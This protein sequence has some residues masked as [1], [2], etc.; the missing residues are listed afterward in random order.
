MADG[1]YKSEY[2]SC[3]FKTSETGNFRVQADSVIFK[4]V[5]LIQDD[6]NGKFTDILLEN[7][8][9]RATHV[10]WLA[11]WSDRIYLIANS[12][13]LSFVNAVNLGIEP[14]AGLH[15]DSY[16]GVFEVRDKLNTKLDF[17]SSLSP[18]VGF[19]QLPENW[20]SYLLERPFATQILSVQFE[21]EKFFG[22]IDKGK[23]D[24]VRVG[25]NLVSAKSDPR[26]EA[27]AEVVQ[28]NYRT[29]K[30][31]LFELASVGDRLSSRF[32]NK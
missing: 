19:P 12:Q 6:G 26:F 32:E 3:T 23:A 17:G 20:A 10:S 8:K 5:T 14:R 11:T 29:A 22:T 24:G 4:P 21:G 31:Q 2:S 30:I 7:S 28:V 18:V 16:I 1:T 15:I 27:A 25:M 13:L 9:N